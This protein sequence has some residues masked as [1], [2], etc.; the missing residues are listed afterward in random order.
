MAYWAA[1]DNKMAFVTIVFMPSVAGRILGLADDFFLVSSS[2]ESG[3]GHILRMPCSF[4]A[5]A[6]CQGI[7]RFKPAV[8]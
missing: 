7:N 5:S 3:I 1:R 8:K 4:F 2:C 6:D